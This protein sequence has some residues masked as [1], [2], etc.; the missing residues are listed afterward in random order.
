V[1]ASD[2]WR[3]VPWPAR[4]LIKLRMRSPQEGART[5]LHCATSLDAAG[6]TG[7]YYDDSRRKAPSAA[8]TPALAAELWERTTSWVQA[9][10]STE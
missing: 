7:Q 4:S 3:R 1:I 5:S 6:E 10:P 9:P 8:A 2:I